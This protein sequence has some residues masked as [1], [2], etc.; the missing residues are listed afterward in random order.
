[1][2]TP[3]YVFLTEEEYQNVRNS[4]TLSAHNVGVKE[5]SKN[6]FPIFFDFETAYAHARKTYLAG[7]H[8]ALAH[9]S[10]SLWQAL[11]LHFTDKQWVANL[12]PQNGEPLFSVAKGHI[13]VRSD[14]C[15]QG[16]SASMEA[17]SMSAHNV[18]EW[19]SARL[20]KRSK[21]ANEKCGECGILEAVA[22]RGGL[23]NH[24]R[25]KAADDD[26][27]PKAYCAACWDAYFASKK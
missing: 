13:S 16:V 22:W 9:N 21:V 15:L 1:M 24:L 3:A 23:G 26:D 6:G 11:T 10:E 12:L 19:A 25:H 8:A 2:A 17:Y 14:L 5:S 27:T 20:H 4:C 7:Q 18:E